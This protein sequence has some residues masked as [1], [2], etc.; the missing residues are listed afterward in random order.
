MTNKGVDDAL[1]RLS[2][3]LTA[4]V[5][6]LDSGPG[7]RPHR[8]QIHPSRRQASPPRL[9]DVMAWRLVPRDLRSQLAPG[10]GLQHQPRVCGR[11]S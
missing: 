8:A 11:R 2:S 1:S 4:I 7:Y 5:N 3:Y 9:E 10:P 6:E